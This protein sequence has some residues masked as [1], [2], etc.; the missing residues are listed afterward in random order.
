[1]AHNSRGDLMNRRLLFRVRRNRMFRVAMSV[2]AMTCARMMRVPMIRGKFSSRIVDLPWKYSVLASSSV[3][4]TL[5]EGIERKSGQGECLDGNTQALS[6][7]TWYRWGMF[8]LIRSRLG[9]N[10]NIWRC[11]ETL[12]INRG[13]NVF[14]HGY[15]NLDKIQRSRRSRINLFHGICSESPLE[16]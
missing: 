2:S 5:F 7:S 8:S 1:M 10:D 15:V 9:C 3:E 14:D 4:Y 13:K 6:V 12:I 16:S 11:R